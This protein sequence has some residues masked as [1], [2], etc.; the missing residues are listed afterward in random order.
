MAASIRGFASAAQTVSASGTLTI[1][2][3]SLSVASVAGDVMLA[4]INYNNVDFNNSA[5]FG[6]TTP[7][8]WTVGKAVTAGPNIDWLVVYQR[9]ATGTAADDFVLNYDG[10]GSG[11]SNDI[12]GIVVTIQNAGTPTFGSVANGTFVT[13][14]AIPSVGSTGDLLLVNAGNFNGVAYTTA[15]SGMTAVTS[16]SSSGA[17]VESSILYQQTLGTPGIRT[18]ASATGMY[19]MGVAVAVPVPASGSTLTAAVSIAAS[20]TNSL[21]FNTTAAASVTVSASAVDSLAYVTTAAASV[22]VSAVASDSL[23]FPSSAVAAVNLTATASNTP[24]FTSTATASITLTAT[25]VTLTTP[26]V[27]SGSTGGN[28]L[29]GNASNVSV[30][31]GAGITAAVVGSTGTTSTLTGKG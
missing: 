23:S 10:D 7:T 22:T 21:R 4:F 16:R 19:V 3:S 15:P 29:A 5:A 24:Y 6:P 11:L 9:I 17:S 2:R 28:F 31:G 8:G 26:G 1:T 30:L 27:L 14:L 20:A 13:S 25:T 18:V 12:T